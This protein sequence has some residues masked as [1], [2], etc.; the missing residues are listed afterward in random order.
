MSRYV[1]SP[2]AR[3]GLERIWDYSSQRWDDDQAEEYLREIQR[4]IERAV[5]LAE[6]GDV[7][8]VAGK[9]H[10]QGQDVGGVVTPFDDREVAREAL[11][12]RS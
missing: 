10:E 2:A 8:V 12:G 6:S 3:A 11:R 7:V 4:A 1:L 5:S 9:G